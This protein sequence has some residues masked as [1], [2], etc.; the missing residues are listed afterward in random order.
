VYEISS[1]ATPDQVNYDVSP[2]GSVFSMIRTDPEAGD[3]RPLRMVVGW[4]QKTMEK[5]EQE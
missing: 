4:L 1:G 5:L 2:N 3:T